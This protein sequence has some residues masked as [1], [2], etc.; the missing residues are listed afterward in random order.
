MNRLVPM[1]FNVYAVAQHVKAIDDKKQQ[2]RHPETYVTIPSGESIVKSALNDTGM[3][4]RKKCKSL[5]RRL[6]PGNQSEASVK[7]ANNFFPVVKKH[8]VD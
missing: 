8:K 7:T 5:E 6:Q 4:Q 2:L 3:I 1:G